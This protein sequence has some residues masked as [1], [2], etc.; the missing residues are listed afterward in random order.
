[1]GRG[2]FS[3]VG[4][5]GAAILQE[6]HLHDLELAST[7]TRDALERMEQ[8]HHS[9]QADQFSARLERLERKRQRDLFE[10]PADVMVSGDRRE[11]R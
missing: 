4:Y 2:E 10:E 9:R 11:I 8:D 5:E 3:A 7:I 6:H 1:M